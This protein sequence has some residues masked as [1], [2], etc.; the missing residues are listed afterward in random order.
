MGDYMNYVQYHSDMKIA[1]MAAALECKCSVGMK[2]CGG[3]RRHFR[4]RSTSSEPIHFYLEIMD[5]MHF[6]VLHLEDVALR[7]NLDVNPDDA[8]NEDDLVDKSML[9]LSN[10]VRSKREQ[11]FLNRM[12]D[13]KQNGKYTLC[14]NMGT[15]VEFESGQTART[16]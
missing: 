7:V 1:K 8:K 3:M 13:T 12:D 11:N 6:N 15:E 4:D 2:R 10:A 5:T 14:S 16:D 9:R